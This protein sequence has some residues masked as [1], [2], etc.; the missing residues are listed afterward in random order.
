MKKKKNIRGIA[1]LMILSQ[2]LLAVFVFQRIY[3]RYGEEEDV[4]KEAISQTF[5]K[6]KQQVIDSMLKSRVIDPLIL[7]SDSLRVSLN[8]DNDY[9]ESLQQGNR[10]SGH[11]RQVIRI[12]NG[13]KVMVYRNDSSAGI[14]RNEGDSSS[15]NGSKDDLLLREIK[16][17]INDS[18]NGKQGAHRIED[19]FHANKIDTT[20][21]KKI[22][23]SNFQK[24]GFL[25]PLRWL[26]S[27]RTIANESM[28]YFETNFFKTSYGLGITRYRL[29]LLQKILPEILF[30]F[31]LLFI[32]GLAFLLSYRSLKKQMKLNLLK[33]DFISNISHELKTPVS[34]VKLSLEALLKFDSLR[35]P[36]VMKEYLN[37]ASQETERLET[38]ISK[39]MNSS[40]LETGG[41]VLEKES[42]NLIS[43]TEECLRSFKP[44]FE[45]QGAKVEMKTESGDYDIQAD[46]ALLRGVLLNLLDN[47]LK[48][49]TSDNRIYIRFSVREEVIHLHVMDNGPGIPEEYLDKVTERFFR[50]PDNKGHRVKGHG[51]GLNFAAQ[52]MHLHRGGLV[53]HNRIEGGL[54]VELTFPRLKA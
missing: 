36:E 14:V 29:Y 33:D 4:L 6:S 17:V 13:R 15:L 25:F 21:L 42:I 1:L 45:Q 31:A 34:T 50:V 16:L 7:Q 51:L 38:L 12:G 44:R 11:F 3:N 9:S 41:L 19:L 54:H 46:K 8:T 52:V 28:L 39:V 27:D 24:N 20:L 23:R 5:L 48:Y 49:R 40:L 10:H 22:I 32:T 2:V 53:I 18:R 37:M 26:S 35:E 47:S 43:L 30:V